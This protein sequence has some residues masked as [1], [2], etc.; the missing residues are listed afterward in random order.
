MIDLL[1]VETDDGGD[2]V[3]QGNDL[4]MDSIFGT[5]IYLALFGGYD[6]WANDLLLEGSQKYESLTEKTLKEVALNSGGRMTIEN[7]IRNDLQ[8]FITEIP[9]TTVTV[10]AQVVSDDKMDIQILINNEAYILQFVQPGRLIF[11]RRDA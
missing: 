2:L 7:A 9:G 5:M 3:Q 10:S 1:M 11:V 4:L 8:F 6:F